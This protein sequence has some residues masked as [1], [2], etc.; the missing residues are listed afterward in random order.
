MVS[1]SSPQLCLSVSNAIM[2]NKGRR[3]LPRTR[4][5]AFVEAQREE[6]S[7]KWFRSFMAKQG[8]P[9]NS[10]KCDSL[11]PK[12]EHIIVKKLYN[13]LCEFGHRHRDRDK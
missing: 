2:A 9:A 5:S 3:I 6:L 11:T 7:K 4:V 12:T 13:A 8:H 1:A 10:S